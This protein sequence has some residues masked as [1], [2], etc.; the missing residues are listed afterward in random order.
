MPC[1]APTPHSQVD[2][3][4]SSAAKSR[5]ETS[6]RSAT[7]RP[8]ARRL[9]SVSSISTGQDGWGDLRLVD[10]FSWRHLSISSRELAIPVQLGDTSSRAMGRFLRCG[11]HRSRPTGPDQPVQ[12]FAFTASSVTPFLKRA[13]RDPRAKTAII[14]QPQVRS[15]GE[16]GVRLSFGT[17]R[18]RIIR[19]LRSGGPL[20]SLT[21]VQI[22]VTDSVTRI[23]THV[24]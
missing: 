24:T 15:A 12:F 11:R 13:R 2:G 17:G 14:Y 7:S 10:N 8:T 5:T 16:D 4:T 19:A 1:M 22:R 3:L 18:R 9:P 23:G 20:D 21:D 6:T